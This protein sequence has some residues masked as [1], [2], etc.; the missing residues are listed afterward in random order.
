MSESILVVEDNNDLSL[1][2]KL[3][4][5]SAGYHVATIDDGRNALTQVEKI[6]PRLIVMD[7]MMPEVNGLH[8]SRTIKEKPDYQ[9]LPILLVSAI[10]RLKDEQL[11]TSRAD[12]IIYKPFDIDQLIAKVNELTS[13]RHEANSLEDRT[14]VGIS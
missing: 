5:E 4:L 3:V 14:E 11:Y 7:I 10:D 1:L 12:G 9:S 13:D 8:V 6:Q 2:F